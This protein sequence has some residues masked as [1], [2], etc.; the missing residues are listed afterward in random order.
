MTEQL[1]LALADRHAGQEAN[2]A[3]GVTALR[4]DRSRAEEA[5]AELARRGEPFTADDVHALIL[6]NDPTPYGRNLVSSVI[7]QWARNAS[8]VE[9]RSLRPVASAQRSRRASRNRWWIGR[10]EGASRG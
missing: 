8:I 9:D 4:D 10:C 2:L 6:R 1:A 5:V 3:A 7:G